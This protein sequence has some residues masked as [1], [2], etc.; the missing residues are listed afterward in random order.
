MKNNIFIPILIGIAVIAVSGFLVYQ[1]QSAQSVTSTSP[2]DTSTSSG[3]PSD[4]SVNQGQKTSDGTQAESYT[5]SEVATHSNAVSCWTIIDNNVYDLTKWIPQ[6]P[7]GQAAIL[8]LCGHDGS[9]AFHGQHDDA[10][11][12]ADIL[13]TFKIGALAK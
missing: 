9:A 6:H 2:I 12:Q 11:R 10:K 8:R 13:A 1:N 5:T 3:T 4:S 7:G